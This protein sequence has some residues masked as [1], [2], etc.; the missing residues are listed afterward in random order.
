MQ[1]AI[2]FSNMRASFEA[3]DASVS[4]AALFPRLSQRERLRENAYS[5]KACSRKLTARKLAARN[6]QGESLQRKSS[7][8]ECS[9]VIAVAFAEGGDVRA[10]V[11]VQEFPFLHAVVTTS[12]CSCSLV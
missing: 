11:Q 6:I 4:A 2:H 5:R 9:P 1:H 7:Q 8:R 3:A 12:G 10:C